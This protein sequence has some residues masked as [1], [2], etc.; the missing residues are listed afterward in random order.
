MLNLNRNF[1]HI[2]K[3]VKILK[4]EDTESGNRDSISGMKVRRT[5]PRWQWGRPQDSWMQCLSNFVVHRNHLGFFKAHS[6][7]VNLG[8]AWE[9]EFLTSSPHGADAAG[10]GATL[11]IAGCREQTVQIVTRGQQRERMREIHLLLEITE[12]VLGNN[13]II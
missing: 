8:R 11:C 13:S 1:I 3:M 5:F 6:D 7:S 12:L 2:I 10:S 4:K 9:S